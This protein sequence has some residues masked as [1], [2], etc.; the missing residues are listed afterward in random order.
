VRFVDIQQSSGGGVDGEWWVRWQV[1]LALV[2]V[3]VVVVVVVAVVVVVVL[4]A[5]A[6]AV[7][8]ART[9]GSVRG[10]TI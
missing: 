6:V 2:V 7:V 9:S 3:V 4:V 1:V 10:D 5:V 8:L